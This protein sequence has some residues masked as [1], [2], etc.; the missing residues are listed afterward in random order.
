MFVNSKSEQLTMLNIKEKKQLNME[1]KYY[2]EDIT[3]LSYSL[4]NA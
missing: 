1:Q 4:T 3:I 2:T